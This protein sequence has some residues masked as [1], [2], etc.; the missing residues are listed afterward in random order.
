M[1][2][3]T[4]TE[5]LFSSW[6]EDVLKAASLSGFWYLVKNAQP[7]FSHRRHQTNSERGIGNKVAV[8]Y[9]SKLPRS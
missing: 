8:L 2:P 6:Y 9:S 3:E 5:I 4:G 7:G 1:W